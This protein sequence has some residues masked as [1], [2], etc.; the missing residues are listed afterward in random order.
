MMLEFVSAIKSRLQSLAKTGERLIVA[1]DSEELFVDKGG[2]RI[3]IR[4]IIRLS[5]DAERTA[6]LAPLDKLYFVV[7]TGKLWSYRNGWECLNPAQDNSLL[8]NYLPLAGGTM[9]GTIQT[10]GE[11]VKNVSDGSNIT[12]MGATAWNK[13]AYLELNGNNG[14]TGAFNLAAMQP[15]GSG[16]GN[17]LTGTYSGK[18][19]WQG[20]NIVRFIDGQ[21]ADENGNVHTA[22]DG[23]VNGYMKFPNGIILQWGQTGYTTSETTMNITFPIV[24]PNKILNVTTGVYSTHIPMLARI[25]AVSTTGLTVT[26]NFQMNVSNGGSSL[27]WMTIGW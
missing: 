3:Q 22:V 11:A 25:T 20:V 8:A 27:Y 9:S 19:Q 16:T 14:N 1:S 4:D 13:G 12:I 5:T 10:A 6:T 18:L 26:F 17:I 15:D 2:E 24:Y 21:P 7:S 23:S